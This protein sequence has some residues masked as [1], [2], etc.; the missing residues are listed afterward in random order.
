[1]DQNEGSQIANV[2]TSSANTHSFLVPILILFVILLS[3]IVAGGAVY[4]AFFNKCSCPLVVKDEAGQVTDMITANPDN[5]PQVGNPTQT[6]APTATPFIYETTGNKEKCSLE[7]NSLDRRGSAIVVNYTLEYKREMM[8]DSVWCP[9]VHAVYSYFID[10][11]SQ[12]KYEAIKDGNLKTIEDRPNPI[13][14]R[15]ERASGYM[16]LT[17]PPSG[18]KVDLYIEGYQPIYGIQL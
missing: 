1:M 17:A 11:V 5:K 18:A 12:I 15:N 7:I 9:D 14:D 16:Q 13:L 8:K 4:L 6:P 3:A 10:P 2:Q